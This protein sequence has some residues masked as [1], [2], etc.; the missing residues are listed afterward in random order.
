MKQFGGA[1]G[2]VFLV[3][4]EG[5]PFPFVLKSYQDIKPH[6]EELFFTE[7][8]NWTSFGVHQNI[9]KTLFA[10]KIEGRIFVAA[11][12]VEPNDNDENRLTSYIGKD[13]PLALI[14]K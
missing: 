6:L 1:M 2:H 11:E 12:F 14:I 8:K 13:V 9:V 3:E 5:I 7:A 10:E 4:K